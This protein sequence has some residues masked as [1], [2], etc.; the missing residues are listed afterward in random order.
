MFVMFKH[1]KRVCSGGLSN[2]E[3]PF[4]LM[5]SRNPELLCSDM[6]TMAT[7]QTVTTE[8]VMTER[9]TMKTGTMRRATT[10]TDTTLT[11]MTGMDARMIESQNPTRMKT[12]KRMRQ[13]KMTR[14]DLCVRVK[15]ADMM[16]SG[17]RYTESIDVTCA[18]I[19]GI[20]LCLGAW[21]MDAGSGLVETVATMRSDGAHTVLR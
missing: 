16:V 7:M 3:V 5:S 10:L 14:K 1:S 8:M 4:K 21:E 2:L 12:M 18:D 20:D 9:V 11:G 15:I 17:E 6:I 19:P 13:R